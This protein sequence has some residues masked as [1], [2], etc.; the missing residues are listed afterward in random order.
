MYIQFNS[1][2]VDAPLRI[3][4]RFGYRRTGIKGASIYHRGVDIGRDFTKKET[5]ILVVADGIVINNY[6]DDMRGWVIV[7]N[8][9]EFKTLYQHL[10]EKSKLKMGV[11]VEGGSQLGI[12]GAS[13]KTIR[14]MTVHL[15]FELIVNGVS[16]DPE[17]YL[18]KV[19]KK[20]RKKENDAM[21]R[22]K[23]VE[24]MPES[25]QKYIQFLVDCGALNGKSE[26]DLDITEDMARMLVVS[27]RY[28]D[29]LYDMVGKWNQQL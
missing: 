6:W 1:L 21:E 4:S 10:E 25:L 8:H 22:Y 15:H 12:M 11:S 3:T 7:I 13:T 26:G 29:K 17:S 23:K 18:R 20:D 24:E 27:K 28:M 14:N 5:N 2:P 16:I 9:G 19:I